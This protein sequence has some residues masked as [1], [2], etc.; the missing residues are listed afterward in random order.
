L[1]RRS[2]RPRELVSTAVAASCAG[3]IALNISDGARGIGRSAC[4]GQP[5][6][7]WL[8]RKQGR[9]HSAEQY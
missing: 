5:S 4:P 7:S 9:H 3:R 1:K 2:M 6:T 8:S